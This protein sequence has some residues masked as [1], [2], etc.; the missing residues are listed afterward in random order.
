MLTDFLSTP[1][2]ADITP[3]Q[4]IYIDGRYKVNDFNRCRFMRVDESDNSPCGFFVGA[5]PGKVCGSRDSLSR[6]FLLHPIF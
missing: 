6:S 3:S 1:S 2:I 4:F 5:N